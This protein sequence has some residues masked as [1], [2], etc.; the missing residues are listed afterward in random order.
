MLAGA[1]GTAAAAAAASVLALEGGEHAL[2]WGVA[3]YVI[4]AATWTLADAVGARLVFRGKLPSVPWRPNLMF[5]VYATPRRNL[6]D[7]VSRRMAAARVGNDATTKHRHRHR[8]FATVVGNCPFA[9]VGGAALA[10]AA[11]DRQP[12]KSPLY[13]A[14]E[15]F[16][17]VGIFTAEGDDWAAK[18][19]EVL[20][21]FATAGLEP[22][23][24]ASTRAAAGLTAEID[25]QLVAATRGKEATR[26]GSTVDDAEKGEGGGGGGGRG[27]D[28]NGLE[29][30]MLPRLQRATLRATFEYLAG[31]DLPTAAAA[32]GG[33]ASRPR[34]PAG[35]WEDE[36]L[37]AAT[38]LRA[39]IPAR[40]R[41]VWM[42]S[43]WAYALSPVGRLERARIREARRLPEL[44]LRAA[45]PG[46][47]LDHL[48]R[49]PAHSRRRRG[50]SG[51]IFSRFW[52]SSRRAGL[53]SRDPLLDEATTLL[54]AG[55]DTQSATL[56]WALLRLAGDPAAQR[57]LRAS[58]T[59]DPVAMESLAKKTN[60]QPAW[61][62]TSA[63]AP[64]LEACLRE[65][66]RLHPVAP[67]VARKL[68]SDAVVASGAGDDDDGGGLTLPAGSA[69]GVWLHAVHRDPTVWVD[70]DSFVPS[71]WLVADS[72]AGKPAGSEDSIRS[73]GSNTPGV[74]VLFKG[75]GFMPFATG[76]RACVGQHLA[77]VYMRVVLA[78]LVCAYEVRL[79]GGEGEGDALTP[80]VGFTVT[81]ANA[82]RVRL[83]PVGG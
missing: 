16:A 36:Y 45:V 1:P 47:P 56:S 79:A 74:R 60:V 2:A 21:A 3:L 5:N 27:G 40:A 48:R 8:A 77:W 66:L 71:R 11:L 6:L 24:A 39:L 19:S 31:V 42:L 81:P 50:W 72:N 80:S 64:V 20:G 43:D 28:G 12:V 22:L 67:F 57:E 25:A 63:G 78:R 44:A 49:G 23:A 4:C 33:D 38:D 9:H 34:R 69:A 58:L 61:W 35:V 75:A 54:F 17:G 10:R 30:D 41:S 55:H 7:R 51:S 15:A 26:E 65:T 53:G 52:G 62:R 83:A 37:A 70:P 14:F 18:R 13:R 68:T 82:A 46:S 59:D 32:D 29:V 73:Q 76:P